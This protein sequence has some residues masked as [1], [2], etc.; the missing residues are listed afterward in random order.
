MGKAK[1]SNGYLSD[2]RSFKE[3]VEGLSQTSYKNVKEVNDQGR[4]ESPDCG[5]DHSM[6]NMKHLEGLLERIMDDFFNASY[7]EEVKQ[8]CF[9]RDCK[10]FKLGS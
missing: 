3:V 2:G 8:K 10:C 1:N 9:F 5:K 4:E 7:L 6:A